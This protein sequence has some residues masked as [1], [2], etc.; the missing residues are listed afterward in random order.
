MDS[1]TI[2]TLF[3]M[4]V[5]LA[6]IGIFK[7]NW[8]SQKPAETIQANSTQAGEALVAEAMRVLRAA[9]PDGHW[10]MVAPAGEP[11]CCASPQQIAL[12]AL[13]LAEKGKPHET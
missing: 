5:A 7:T 10:I 9:A 13:L 6:G 12:V 1:S 8:K 4:A 3:W 11:I 2:K